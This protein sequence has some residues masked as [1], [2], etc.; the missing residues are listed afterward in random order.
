MEKLFMIDFPADKI[1]LDVLYKNTK[2]LK[3]MA[4]SGGNNE[5]P[6]KVA[7]VYD[8]VVFPK[9]PENRPYLLSSIVLSA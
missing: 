8:E 5:T 1:R 7:E 4:E 6:A 3:E 2:L 9:A